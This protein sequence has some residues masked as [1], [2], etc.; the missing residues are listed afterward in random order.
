MTEVWNVNIIINHLQKI[1]EDSDDFMDSLLE[2]CW[3]LRASKEVDNHKAL[4]CLYDIQCGFH[5]FKDKSL[6]IAKVFNIFFEDIARCGPGCSDHLH[7]DPYIYLNESEKNHFDAKLDQIQPSRFVGETREGAEREDLEEETSEAVA[8]T[9][10]DEKL[11]VES[12]EQARI[13]TK[14]AESLLTADIEMEMN[15]QYNQGTI[16]LDGLRQQQTALSKEASKII[17]F[18]LAD[19]M[20]KGWIASVVGKVWHQVRCIA[21]LFSREV[22]YAEEKLFNLKGSFKSSGPVIVILKIQSRGPRI[23][24]YLKYVRSGWTPAWGQKAALNGSLLD[25]DREY[26]PSPF[27]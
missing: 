25:L 22:R 3:Y 18:E 4:D 11:R 19:I 16:K 14:A 1:S 21:W 6:N 17:A 8:R 10:I 7:Y 24:K 20:A 13:E 26:P 5:I 27:A 23:I 2:K 9:T 15:P 12:L